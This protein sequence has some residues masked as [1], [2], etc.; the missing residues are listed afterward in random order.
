M[1]RGIYT[2]AAAMLGETQRLNVTSN[3]LANVNT[4]GYK[5]DVAVF[6]SFEELLIQRIHEVDGQVNQPAGQAPLGRLGTG[7]YLD[8][9]VTL[10]RAGNPVQTGNRRDL[11]IDGAG[12]FAVQSAGGEVRYTRSLSLHNPDGPATADGLIPLGQNGP[13]PGRLRD[14]T[15]DEQGQVL[16]AAGNVIDRL[17]VVRFGD[18]SLL[19]KEGQSLFRLPTP[20]ELAARQA[21]AAP[22]IDLQAA[23]APQ[24][25]ANP[26]VRVGMI[27]ASNV[28]PVT[29]MVEMISIMRAYE[30][31]QKAIQVQD[32]TLDKL[33]N[34]VARV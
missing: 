33:I 28:N 34:D 17:Q 13:L 4:A 16:D 7:A 25:V 8:Q 30:A 5:R 11:S 22:E 32:G 20:D 27:E 26:R 23:A 31:N 3:N 2:S 15:V 21:V 1:L 9:I 12:F 18:P 10:H 29:E 24:Q 19:V 6:R 14:F